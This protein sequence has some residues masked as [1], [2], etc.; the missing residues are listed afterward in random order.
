M[1]HKDTAYLLRMLILSDTI[2]KIE[3]L[4]YKEGINNERCR[5]P[6]FR[7]SDIKSLLRLHVWLY[8]TEWPVKERMEALPYKIIP[9]EKGK[10]PGTMY[11]WSV[12]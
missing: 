3:I 12:L 4:F 5:N 8:H 7:K 6:E 2:R 1:Y 10:F 11:F 9:G